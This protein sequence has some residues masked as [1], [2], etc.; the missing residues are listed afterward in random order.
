M[1]S[2]R[3]QQ[4]ILRVADS[5]LFGV[6]PRTYVLGNFQPSLAGLISISIVTQD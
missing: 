5:L 3:K 6:V 4:V 2:I 1:A